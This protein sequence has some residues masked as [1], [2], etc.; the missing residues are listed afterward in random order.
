MNRRE[1]LAKSAVAAAAGFALPAFTSCASSGSSLV[2]RP[3]PSGRINLGVIG[4]G[5]IAT[6]TVPNFLSDDRVQVVAIADPVTDMPHYGEKKGQ[7]RGGRLVG[8]QAVEKYYAEFRPAGTFKGCR[9]YE[10]FREM[11]AREDLDAVYIATPDHWHCAMA[12]LA[13]RKGKHIY[14]QKP[15]ALTV[16]EG[17]RIADAAQAA[18]ITFQVG[19]QQRSMEYFRR[20]CELVRNGR[21]G[22]IQEVVVGYPGGNRDWS[23]LA[24]QQ[25]PQ[26]APPE[27]NWDLWLGPAPVHPY[28]PALHPMNWRYHFDFGGGWMTDWGAH[29][30]DIVQWALG[31]DATGPVAIENV[32][33]S[34]PPPGAFFNTAND[35]AYDLVYADGV[36]AKV[37]NRNRKG[38]LF[39]GENGRSLFVERNAFE[40]NPESLRRERPGP[41]ELHLYES[42]LQESNFIDCIYSGKPAIT[43]AE[44]GHRSITPSHLA[45]IAIRLGRSRLRWD[46]AAER[47]IGD[48]EA[49]RM[50]SRPMRRPYAV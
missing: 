2:R 15:L 10:D 36:R 1:F 16:G 19:S 39:T 50:L 23:G 6:T 46:P 32:S 17:R 22:R 7:W 25:A 3:A 41:G 9:V 20:A 33:A 34:L 29:Q 24:A 35:F 40:S 44:T 31:A 14:C 11:L 26:P 18:G 27:M 37:S 21:L 12:L 43:P 45:N 30:I 48:D 4:Y 28:A 47:V 38:I 49:N 5:T 42:R 8:A 13:A